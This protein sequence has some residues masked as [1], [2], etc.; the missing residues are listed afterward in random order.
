MDDVN[1]NVDVVSIIDYLTDRTLALF[2]KDAAAKGMK[3]WL[4]ELQRISYADAST[5]QSIGMHS[6]VPLETIYQPTKIRIEPTYV[7]VKGKKGEKQILVPGGV[8]TPQTLL[9]LSLSFAIIAGPGWG[10]T[11]LL[12]YLYLLLSRDP[13]ELPVLFTLRRRSAVKDLIRFVD[14]LHKVK[15]LKR[16]SRLTLLVDGYD[17]VS[18]KTRQTISDALLRFSVLVNGRLYLS[19]REFYDIYDIKL[20]QARLD[21]FDA[22][23]QKRYATS[24][25]AIYGSNVNVDALLNDLRSRGMEDLLAHPLLLSLVCIVK[26]GRMS[27]NSRSVITLIDRAIDT[28]SF[29]WD[30]GKG[31]S[32]ESTLPVPVDGRDR[33]KCLMRIAYRT[34][35]AKVEERQALELASQQLEL[36]RWD[37][38]DAKQML[39]ETAR[40]YG[41]FVPTDAGDW[42]FVHKTLHDYLGA[43]FWV[44]NG[45]FQASSIREWNTKAAYAA[46]L[47]GDAT[48]SLLSALSD[49]KSLPAFAEML[50]NDASFDH[51]RVAQAV[52]K[53]YE[54]SRKGHYFRLQPKSIE[55][56]LSQDFI[57]IAS[58]KFLLEIVEACSRQRSEVCDGL[59]AY[60]LAELYSRKIRLPARIYIKL[61]YLYGSDTFLFRVHSVQRDSSWI[62]F[63]LS[64][65]K[66]LDMDEEED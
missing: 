47:T 13:K 18:Q 57:S 29:R 40:F 2:G 8:V 26:S 7:T 12:H 39:L 31:V 54:Q 51:V 52:I 48:E 63:P 25:L 24:F 11:T 44:E 5:V 42:Q 37:Y 65:L 4:N 66:P 41:I 21:R 59:A 36:L 14:E 46:C 64:E 16:D 22:E 56:Q 35:V 61:V 55:V 45:L 3:E 27:V 49:V 23:D 28:L 58:T 32:R 19:C 15:K 1:V 30:E 50:S 34:G 53:H 17:E 60:A 9:S 62:I 43:R 38:V 6:P 33:V 20:P 10:K